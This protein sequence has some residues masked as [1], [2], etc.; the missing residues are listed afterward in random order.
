M[1]AKIN[2]GNAI[3]AIVFIPPADPANRCFLATVFLLTFFLARNYASHYLFEQPD[4]IISGTLRYLRQQAGFRHARYSV[5]LKNER[6][7]L[8]IDNQIYPG[9]AATAEGPVS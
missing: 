1:A 2:K 3:N 6:V 4:K 9:C 8:I 5:H 7:A